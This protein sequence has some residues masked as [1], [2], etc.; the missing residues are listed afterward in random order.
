MNAVYQWATV[1][2]LAAIV[3]AMI[4]LITPIGR[5]ETVSYT[6]LDVYKRQEYS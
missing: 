2:C 3:G 1:V 4:E 6:H 5:M